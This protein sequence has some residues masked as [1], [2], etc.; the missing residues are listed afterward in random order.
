M[1]V[2]PEGRGKEESGLR[3]IDYVPRAQLA[4]A[5]ET[6]HKQPAKVSMEREKGT[7]SL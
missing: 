4:V 7:W 3:E 2:G 5:V 1:R 6:P